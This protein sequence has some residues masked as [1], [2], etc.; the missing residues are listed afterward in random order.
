MTAM[1]IE[2][3]AE[4]SFFNFHA[5]GLDYICLR[6]DPGGETHKLYFLPENRDGIVAPHNHRYD[7]Q[8]QLL[9]GEVEDVR[10]TQDHLMEQG[11]Q[12]FE[13]EWYTPLS[14]G[15]GASPYSEPVRLRR[16]TSVVASR[17][18]DTWHTKAHRIHTLRPL[19]PSVIFLIQ[20]PRKRPTSMI[21]LREGQGFPNLSGLYAKP[22]V[23]DVIDRLEMFA[24]LLEHLTIADNLL[25]VE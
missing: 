19:K 24:P 7:F 6:R 20:K 17:P 12:Y 5:K 15:Y 16:K 9:A 4:N 3:I 2:T 23:D 1:N 11:D 21:Y 8:T 13:H 18:G 25:E 10:Y 14:G 22:T